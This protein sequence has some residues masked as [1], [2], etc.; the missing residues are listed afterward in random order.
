ML[1]NVKSSVTTTVA[2]A[3]VLIL[4]LSVTT[5]GFAI[6]TLASSL[7]DAEAVN[8][9]GSMRMQSYR[10]AHDIQSESVDYSTHIVQFERSIYSDSMKA[11]QNWTVP[12]DITHDYYRLIVRWHELKHVLKGHERDRYL[13]LVAG[14]VNQIDSFVFKLQDYS[15][16]KLISLAWVGGLG[17]GGVLLIS[18]FIVH[19]T[20]KH[21]VKPLN[22]L[23]IASEQIQSRSF[24][25][26][27]NIDSENE[28]G[29]LSKAFNKMARDLGSLYRG[30]EQAV[31][32]KTQK[33]QHANDSLRVLYQS[34]QELTVSRIT[35]DNFSAI[36]K[37][38]VSL[39]GITSV[40]LEI[41]E[42]GE[43]PILLTEGNGCKKCTKQCQSQTLSLDGIELGTLY[44]KVSL[45]CPDQ[46][47]IDNF[48]Q[49]LSRAVYY[50]QAQRQAEQLLV[51]EER[52]TI[53]RELHDSLAQALSYLKIQVSI[54]KRGM[55]KLPE[56]PEL[57]KTTPVLAELDTGL[58]AAYTQLRELLTTFRLSIKEGSFGSALHTMTEQLS[59]QTDAEIK[60]TNELSSIEL[61][62]NQQ[63][64]LL[65]LIREATTNAIK[66]ANAKTITIE[67]NES[68]TH[69]K[70]AVRDD[71][72]GFDSTTEKANHYGLSIMQER[73]SRLNGELSISTNPEQGCEVY[74]EYP[75]IKDSNIDRV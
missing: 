15:E 20:R 38:I 16:K 45:P 68:D 73:A 26:A 75:K 7:N 42:P 29:I 14:F 74:L 40:R 39:E 31:N 51:M 35:Q 44:W 1:K 60:L 64:H 50:N 36:L 11:L 22:S 41:N 71:G 47:L 37:H 52:A 6:F 48:V 57:A 67:C 13:V 33:L 61:D 12:E 2:K 69:I 34:S 46:A 27:L 3:M 4:L 55:K 19:Y 32:E 49:I 72:V 66:H 62:T 63:V 17:L 23:V 8:V 25:I 70:V 5:T 59:D 58:S 24:N 43:R 28:M 54:L 53:A 21:I 10:L 9:A 56:T 30:L 18:I 65:Q